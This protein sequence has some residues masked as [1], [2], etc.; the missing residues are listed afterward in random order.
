[1]H[2]YVLH[3]ISKVRGK[4]PEIKICNCIIYKKDLHRHNYSLI[5]EQKLVEVGVVYSCIQ[6]I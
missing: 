5:N 4:N 3:F 6:Y 2:A 1:M